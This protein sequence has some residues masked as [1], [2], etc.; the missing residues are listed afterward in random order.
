MEK[1]DGEYRGYEGACTRRRF[2]RAAGSGVAA[3][4]AGRCGLLGAAE[5]GKGRPNI[6]ICIADDQSWRDA[7]CYGNPDVKTPNIDRLA[8]EGMRFDRAFTATAMCAPTRQQLYTGVFPVRNGAFPN[9]SRVHAGT[10]SIV[11]HLTALGYRVGLAG[12]THFGPAESFPFEKVPAKEVGEFITRDKNQPFCLV[13]A[14]HSPHLPWSAGDSSAYDP[15]ALTL[16]PDMIDT[17][18]LRAS[19]AK[20]YAEVTDFDRE[21]GVVFAAVRSAGADADTMFI[22][23]SEQGPPFLHGKWTCYDGGLHVGFIV[24]WPRR[25]RAGSVAKAMV[26]YVDVVPTLVEAGGGD[27]TKIDTGRPGAPDGGAGFDG[28]SFLAVLEGKADKHNE[29]VFGAHTTRG[30]ISG[31]ECYP[32]RSIRSET[33]KY[34]RNLNHEP[35]FQN[36]LTDGR[37]KDI[38]WTSY[39]EKARTDPAAARLVRLY[40]H[41]PAEELYDLTKDPYELNNIA[42]DPDA[43]KIKADLGQRLDAWMAQ[44]GDK[45][46][47][48]ELQ[49][50]TRQG[51]GDKAKPKPKNKAGKKKAQ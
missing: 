47:E 8:A 18:Q 17:P 35:P 46:N 26:Q 23:T 21:V 33:H 50:K 43:A 5:A 40:T 16:T 14:S 3:V 44:Q 4:A 36:I 48:T 11:H 39:V 37:S 7:G 25:V 20:Y 1:L 29:Y 28:R 41:R 19:L 49:A 22:C 45:G 12:K 32:I 38:Y 9:H 27:P 13:Y 34:I 51:R 2:L 42:T 30:I 31:S 15:A 10:K 24:R 6:V